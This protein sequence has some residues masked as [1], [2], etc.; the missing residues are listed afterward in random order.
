MAPLAPGPRCGCLVSW[1]ISAMGNTFIIHLTSKSLKEGRGGGGERERL[2]WIIVQGPRGGSIR[3]YRG[4]SAVMLLNGTAAHSATPLLGRRCFLSLWCPFFFLIFFY[5][6]I[7]CGLPCRNTTTTH[8]SADKGAF[9]RR[10][11]AVL[12]NYADASYIQSR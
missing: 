1:V 5:L 2:E 9:I 4:H 3:R 6:L 10:G 8:P 12:G 11:S 7:R